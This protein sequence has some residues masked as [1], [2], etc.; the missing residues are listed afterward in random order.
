MFKLKPSLPRYTITCE[1]KHLL[2]YIRTNSASGVIP[3]EL[4]LKDLATLMCLLSV[5]GTQTLPSLCRDYMF[6]DDTK[7]VFYI[8]KLLKNSHSRFYQ[9]PLEFKAY[10][11]EKSAYVAT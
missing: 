5:Q 10:L 1:M 11:A 3:L 6:L 2:N 8:S 4:I 7:W 9:H